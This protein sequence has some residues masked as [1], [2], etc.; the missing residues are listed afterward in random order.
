MVYQF[1]RVEVAEFDL[2]YPQIYILKFLKR[3]GNLKVSQIADEMKI[4]VYAASRLVDQLEKKKY[5]KR[6]TD[7]NDKR[8][9]YASLTSQG[10][11]IVQK[12][13]DHAFELIERGL[14]SFSIE[15][16]KTI[17]DSVGKLDKILG[18]EPSQLNK[19]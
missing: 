5:V 19:E 7:K 8:I 16:I 13:E 15:E 17:I 9:T 11:A 12:L 18:I 6:I 4:P 10:D 2:L 14:G 1:E 3:M